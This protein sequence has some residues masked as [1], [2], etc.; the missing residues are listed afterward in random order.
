M[1]K[2]TYIIC[3]IMISM[4]LTNC[5]GS[6]VPEELSKEDFQTLKVG[7]EYSLQVPKYMKRIT[8]LHKEA[9]L[10]CQNEKKQTY[11]LVIGEKK[12]EA[13][14]NIKLI[15]GYQDSLTLVQNYR[16]F[17]LGITKESIQV[18]NVSEKKALKINGLNAEIVEVE[19]TV[20]NQGKKV[21]V[22]Y[23]MAFVEGKEKMYMAM[24][25]TSLVRKEKYKHTFRQILQS[26]KQ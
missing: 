24:V 19:G 5:G 8:D 7:K 21:N 25:W 9:S 26:F 12:G 2:L 23:T 4:A 20:E 22:A 14:E 3:T 16:N 13:G 11:L 18:N 1:K 6:K 17:R 15:P 10:Q